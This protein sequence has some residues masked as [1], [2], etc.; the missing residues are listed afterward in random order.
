M[1]QSLKDKVAVVTG[2]SRG[3]GRKIATTLASE[4]ALVAIHY[5][6]SADAAKEVVA[7]IERAGGRAFTVQEDLSQPGA[8]KNLFTKLDAALQTLVG[9]NNIDILV[10]NAGIA[11]FTAFQDTTEEEFDK[12]FAVNVR[13][14]YFLALEAAKRLNDNGR[15][16]NLS[17]VVARLPSAA[18]AAY[19][20]SKG[21]IDTLTQILAAELGPRGI[22]VNAVAP[23]VIQTDMAEPMLEMAGTEWIT[24]TQSVKRIGQT[25]DVAD[26][27][28]YLASPASRWVSGQIIEAAGGAR[29]V[30]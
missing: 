30:Y 21:A 20:T 5:G 9:S 22:V 18:A 7:E 16:V 14:P 29:V 1:S 15:I 6:G 13:A 23:G 24:E 11:P 27:V 3:I 25:E 8:A 4:G 10:N 12:I 26:L 19:S 17:S 28:T 2:A